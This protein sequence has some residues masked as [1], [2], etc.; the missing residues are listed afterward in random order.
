MFSN[1]VLHLFS[2]VMKYCLRQYEVM[3]AAI[4]KYSVYTEFEVKFVLS[5]AVGVFHICKANIS[6]R[7]Y[8]TRSAGTNFIE[9]STSFEV[10][11]SGTDVH[12]TSNKFE[13]VSG[14]Y[15]RP[16]IAKLRFI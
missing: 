9:K 10:L 6:Q 2:C 11:F 3:A 5:Y 15:S 12:N 14:I 7:S 13:S 1:G 4:M 8:F 16:T